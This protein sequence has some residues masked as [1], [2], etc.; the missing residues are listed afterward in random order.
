MNQ[1]TYSVVRSFN[2][3]MA[4]QLG[5]D[6]LA[7]SGSTGTLLL[8]AYPGNYD[9]VKDTVTCQFYNEVIQE[10]G[11][12]RYASGSR[13]RFGEFNAQIDVWSPPNANGEPRQGANRQFKDCVEQALKSRVRI[14]LIDYG[15]AGTSIVG[16]MMVRQ[17]DAQSMPVDDMAGWSRWRLGYRIKALDSD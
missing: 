6:T 14:N 12:G 3:F 1:F 5:T 9:L 11:G 16:G 13:S 2:Q 17:T 4:S 10:V 7:V 15:T 8:N